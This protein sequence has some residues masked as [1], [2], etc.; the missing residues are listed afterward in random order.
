MPEQ[1]K[2]STQAAAHI[3]AQTAA[4]EH[5]SGPLQVLAGPGSGK[6]YLTIRRIR[7]LICHQGV[8]PHQILVITFTKAAALEMEQRFRVLMQEELS[9]LQNHLPF[10]EVRFGTFHAVYYHMLMQ[11]GY[12]SKKKESRLSLINSREQKKY[13]QHILMM[14]GIEDTAYDTIVNLL[15]RISAEKNGISKKLEGEDDVEEHFSDIFRE[16]CDMMKEENKLDFDDMI[17]LCDRMLE[18]R[19]EILAR[20]QKEFSYIL[21]DEFQD[22]S[23]L[24]YRIIQ[25]LAAPSQNL[26]VV[27][28]DDQSIYGFRG[29]GPDIMKQFLKDYPQALQLTLGMNYRCPEKVVRASSLVI[30]ENKNR[31]EKKMEAERQDEG[32]VS[33]CCFS[34]KEEEK[35]WLAA[36]LKTMGQEE[37]SETAIIFRTNAQATELSRHLAEVGIAFCI[38]EKMENIFE[39]FVALDLLSYLQFSDDLAKKGE[40]RR[41]DL[42][43]ILNRPCRYLKRAALSSPNVR[44]EEL[45]KYYTSNTYMQDIV[46][47]F[48]DDLRKLSTLR[49][50]LAINYIRKLMGY[51]AFLKENQRKEEQQSLLETADA[52]QQTAR[53]C[54][55]LKEWQEWILDYGER[56]RWSDKNQDKPAGVNL[57]TMHGSKGLEYHTVFLPNIQMGSLPSP[58]TVAEQIEVERRLFYVAMTRAKHRLEISYHKEPSPFL[59]QLLKVDWIQKRGKGIE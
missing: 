43:R 48:F 44:E 7:H 32:K 57:M 38:R 51:N 31:F 30:Q 19:P 5:A 24:Q 53:T 22:I 45:L 17:L 58:R 21:V 34:S 40:G 10:Q 12:P 28:D 27:G 3:M 25:K 1:N 41:S 4:I 15:R 52:L 20:W 33:I 46:R 14:Y 18:E 47:R 9:S 36:S 8:S 42:L 6:T 56:I 2:F 29:A 26:F 55:T 54:G 23:P 11:S 35:N 13:L 59:H 49:P 37:L 50:W 16:Y 39:H